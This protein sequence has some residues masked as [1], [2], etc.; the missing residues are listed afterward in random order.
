MD[1]FRF[2]SKQTVV[3]FSSAI[4]NGVT[5]L[6]LAQAIERLLVAY[7]NACIPAKLIHIGST[8]I[9]KA[10]LLET[11]S[12]VYNLKKKIFSKAGQP[13]DRSLQVSKKFSPT[14]NIQNQLLDYQRFNQRNT[15]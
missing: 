3:G 12:Q 1:W 11:I 9:S 7:P 8:P 10:E 6:A 15:V 13:V 2:Q 4:W 14:S 5:T